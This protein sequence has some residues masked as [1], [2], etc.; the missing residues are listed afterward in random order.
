MT[1]RQKLGRA[2]IGTSGWS[3]AH[4]KGRFYPPHLSSG[5]WLAHYAG[6]FD[7]VE[8]NGSF[9]RMPTEKAVTA[10]AQRVP[11]EFLFAWKASRYVTQAKRLKD[12]AEPVAYV[13]RRAAGLGAKLGPILFQLPPQMRRD[14]ARLAQFLAL[15]PRDH[16]FAVEFRDPDWYDEAIFRLLEEHGVALCVSDHHDAPAPPLSTAPFVYLRL[17]G[18]GGAY[19]GR[20]PASE[21]AAWA[22]R[23]A[24]WRREGRDVFAYFDNDVDGAAPLDAEA[25]R[26]LTRET[27]DEPKVSRPRR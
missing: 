9:Y 26:E 23:I 6:A 16:R 2:R 5:A 17:H 3:Y 24:R 11:E 13:L 25:L 15:L 14:D 22:D 4:W 21:L 27:A 7:T 18:P 19:A 1:S 8:I 20:Y 12:V 10:W